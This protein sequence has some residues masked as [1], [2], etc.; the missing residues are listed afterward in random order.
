MEFEYSSATPP[1][2]VLPAEED[3]ATLGEGK[4]QIQQAANADS[5]LDAEKENA[6]AWTE[7]ADELQEESRPP[8]P[9]IPDGGLRAW[10]LVL[11]ASNV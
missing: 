9:H 5:K 6:E 1:P 8:V 2:H 3:S 4:L 11:G 7:D 10:L